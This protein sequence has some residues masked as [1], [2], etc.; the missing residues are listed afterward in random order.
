MKEML[1]SEQKSLPLQHEI[2]IQVA[3]SECWF[4]FSAS[5]F[6]KLGIKMMLW[7]E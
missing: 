4:N 3:V 7:K 1:L 5:F 2:S 6:E